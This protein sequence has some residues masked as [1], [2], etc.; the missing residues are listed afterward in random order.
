M[1]LAFRSD[2]AMTR[3]FWPIAAGAVV[4]AIAL[5]GYFNVETVRERQFV[6]FSGEA[7]HNPLLAL[8]RLAQRMGAEAKTLQRAADL[9]SAEH[10]ATL[11]L[12]ADRHGMTPSRIGRVVRW[13]RE[14]GRLVVEAEPLDTR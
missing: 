14:G 9:D 10:G 3:Y 13:V 6:G 8:Q 4:L 12:A 2:P 11:V 7:A 5:W 1:A